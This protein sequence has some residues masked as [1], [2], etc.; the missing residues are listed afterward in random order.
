[1]KRLISLLLLSPDLTSAAANDLVVASG[2]PPYKN[3]WLNPTLLVVV[4][5]LVAFVMSQVLPSLS[6]HKPGSWAHSISRQLAPVVV[7][8]CLFVCLG[9]YGS[10][11]TARTVF[12]ALLAFIISSPLFTRFPLPPLASNVPNKLSSLLFIC[13]RVLVRWAVIVA[14]L[15]FLL[16]AFGI[17]PVFSGKVV[18]TWFVITPI[19]LYITRCMRMQTVKHVL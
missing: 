11:V 17:D 5:F 7:V 6:A 19:T 16:Y 10:H 15:L 14:G 18:L 12:L 1:M 2:S 9:V 13:S 3:V 4:C 8:A